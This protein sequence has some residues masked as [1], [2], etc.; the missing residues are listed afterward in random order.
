MTA[1][2]LA[3]HNDDETLFGA[4]VI[5][6][7]RAHVVTVLRSFYQAQRWPTENYGHERREAE[8][9]AAL[10]ELGAT[11]EQWEF[12]DLEPD[13]RSI[14]NCLQ[15][16]PANGMIFAPFP[17]AVDGHEHHDELGRLAID[18]FGRNRVLL[19]TTYSRGN[20]RTVG[21]RVDPTPLEI[22]G[23]LRA[24]ACYAS[25][26]ENWLCRPHF[27]RPLDEYLATP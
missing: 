27:L 3:P 12:D 15:A 18:V 22:A 19:Y 23:K 11:G 5:Q 6:R 14:R 8:T 16:T 26:H 21:D 13:W 4:F 7:Q 9:A 17:E 1:L 24:M 25:Q 2:F 20:G 10:V